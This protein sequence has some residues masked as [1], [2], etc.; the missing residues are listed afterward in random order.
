MMY[1]YIITIDKLG[2]Y[3]YYRIPELTVDKR[4]I[5]NDALKAEGT[6]PLSSKFGYTTI[7]YLCN[8]CGHSIFM[9]SNLPFTPE[10]YPELFI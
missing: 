2:C 5:L 8:S 6:F 10:Y 1:N 7:Q 4:M 9:Q 3:S